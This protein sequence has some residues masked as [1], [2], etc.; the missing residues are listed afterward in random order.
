MASTIEV[1]IAKLVS[2]QG[3]ED[4]R[5]I[6]ESGEARFRVYALPRTSLRIRTARKRL[7]RL[8]EGK[9]ARLE[10]SLTRSVIEAKARGNKPV[11]EDFARLV[12]DYKAAAA[13][14]AFLWMNGIV[15]FD[16]ASIGSNLYVASNALSQKTYE[17]RIAKV[18]RASFDINAEKVASLPS[19]VIEC[20]YRDGALACKYI[21]SNCAK[22]QAKA[23]IRGV[24]DALMGKTSQ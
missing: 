1:D 15:V 23:E 7:V 12:G 8:D 20:V 17:H 14:L 16:D 18:L 9:V 2:G 19:D 10:Y 21:V 3:L 22:S 6:I 11:F 4:A 5:K 24:V 13:Y